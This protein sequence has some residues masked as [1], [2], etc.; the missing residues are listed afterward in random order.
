MNKKLVKLYLKNS[1]SRDNEDLPV[2]DY[3]NEINHGQNLSMLEVGS[4]ECRFAKKIAKLYPNIKITC[5]EINPS[6]AKIAADCGFEVLNEDILNVN[7][8]REYDI[9]HC[10]HVIE[11]FGYP[12]VTQLLDFLVNSTKLNMCFILRSPL[13]HKDFYIDIDHIRPYP[14][15]AIQNYFCL[16]QQQKQSAANIS[17]KKLWY[18]TTPKIKDE[19][20]T[21]DNLYLLRHF[22]P[23]FN[24]IIRFIN[25]INLE[26]WNRF[27]VP[28]SKP[29]GYVMIIKVIQK[30]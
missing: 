28:S 10:S 1:S 26:L 2:L 16:K 30:W 4:G 13:M 7:A 27:R 5:I 15:E 24:R 3:I 19:L 22:R 18:R 6:L 20:Q 25:K 9:V 21:W 14:P 17:V 12:Q 29:N 8:T 11:H 23:L